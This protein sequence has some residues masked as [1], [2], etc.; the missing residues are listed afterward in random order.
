MQQTTEWGFD[1]A[2]R[3]VSIAGY[4]DEDTPSTKQT[5]T[6][7]YDKLGRVVTITYPDTKTIEYAYN[8]QGGVKK[9]TDQRDIVTYY[10]YNKLRAMTVRTTDPAVAC[11]PIAQDP[12]YVPDELTT[13]RAKSATSYPSF[14]AAFPASDWS[15]SA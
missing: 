6:Y 2:G 9:R 4:T 14:K 3:Q 12:N 1:R 10:G 5:T 8:D 13:M 11:D 15:S 7:D